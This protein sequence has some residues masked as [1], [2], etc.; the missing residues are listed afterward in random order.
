MTA[1]RARTPSDAAEPDAVLLEVRDLRTHFFTQEGVVRAVDGVDLTVPLG[2]T[3]CVVGESGCGKSVTA[4]SILSL[5]D[6]PGRIVGGSILFRD[7][8]GDTVDLA[9]LDPRS[10]R[11]RGIRGGEIA[12]IFQEPMASLSPMYTIGAHLVETI[13]LH[14][15]MDQKTAREHAIEMLRRVGIPRPEQRIDAYS[16]QLSGGMCQ[17]AMIAMAL[18]CGPSLLIADE[19]TTALDVTTQAR[20]LDLIK[21]LQD[22]TGMSVLFIT[23]DLGVVAEIADEVV[24]MYLGTVVERGTVDEIFHDPKHPYTQALLRSIPTIGGGHPAA[25]DPDPGHGAAPVGP[26]GRLPVPPPLRP[27]H[28][29][30][31]RRQR[32]ADDRDRARAHRPLRALRRRRRR[33]PG[34]HRDRPARHPRP[35]RA[36][37]RSAGA[38]SAGRPATSTRWTASTCRSAPARRSV[39]SA[40]PA[41]ARPRWAG[42]SSGRCGR[43][44]GRIRYRTA[45]GREVDLAALSTPRPAA[46]PAPGPAHLPGPVLV[47]EPA[48]DAAAR[49]SATRCGPTAWPRARSWRTGWPTC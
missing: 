22:Q 8:A 38:R 11:M 12:M 23:H 43:T 42:P 6:R 45:D 14:M 13:R 41:A 4:R 2:R 24:V 29:R 1:P 3:V 17:R 37:R 28:R 9:A 10:V 44:R 31:L 47:A 26:A 15:S 39:S 32:P 16:F 18:A 34:A 7:K 33:P 20:I 21:D 48:H 36:L 46:V 49:S 25:A 5:V 35:G 27:R 40:S 19:P 30:G